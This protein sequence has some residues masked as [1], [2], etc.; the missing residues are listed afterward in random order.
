MV[1]REPEFS[2]PVRGLTDSDGPGSADRL[3]ERFK[4]VE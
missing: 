1:W 3:R 4:A 2:Q